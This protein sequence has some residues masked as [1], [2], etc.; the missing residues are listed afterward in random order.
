MKKLLFCLLVV[1][2]VTF[3]AGA[4]NA[5]I[6]LRY[7]VMSS[8]SKNIE[9]EIWHII[10]DVDTC[11]LFY[12]QKFYENEDIY[13]LM[14][15][16]LFLRHEIPYEPIVEAEM[17]NS[18]VS[19][20]LQEKIDI[21][22]VVSIS[23]SNDGNWML[24]FIVNSESDINTLIHIIRA[25]EFEKRKITYRFLMYDDERVSWCDNNKIIK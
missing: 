18:F 19:S 9:D 16:T 12:D 6:Y 11:F 17:F 13:T 24:Y 1:F 10:E 8:R 7:D 4:K 2:F 22:N 20:R 23:G 25:S 14:N 15:S 3:D 21:K 5:I